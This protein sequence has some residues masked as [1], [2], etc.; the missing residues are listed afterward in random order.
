MI[1]LRVML[2]NSDLIALAQLQENL[3]TSLAIS[4]HYTK[5]V[6]FIY[7]MRVAI[8]CGLQVHAETDE[9]KETGELHSGKENEIKGVSLAA[10]RH[11]VERVDQVAQERDTYRVNAIRYLIRRGLKEG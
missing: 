11:L 3:N 10:P 2:N 7:T 4:A 6:S 9:T 8:V 1:K 5:G